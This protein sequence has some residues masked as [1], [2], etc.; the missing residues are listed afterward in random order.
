M[1]VV[2]LKGYVSWYGKYYPKEEIDEL[3]KGRKDNV[4]GET[5]DSSSVEWIFLVCVSLCQNKGK[6][7]SYDKGKKKILK[8]TE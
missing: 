1:I 4:D 5:S 6:S 3:F 2:D 7:Y 8:H